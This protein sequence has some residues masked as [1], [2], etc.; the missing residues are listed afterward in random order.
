M[1]EFCW[2]NYLLYEGENRPLNIRMQMSK[3]IWKKNG[4][5]AFAGSF[6]LMLKVYNKSTV[7]FFLGL[8][9]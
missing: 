2:P 6:L 7:L 4:G 1:C 8:Y 3:W 9:N 5:L